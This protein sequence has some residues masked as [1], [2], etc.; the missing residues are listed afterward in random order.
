MKQ[1]NLKLTE[2]LRSISDRSSCDFRVDDD[3]RY[4]GEDKR[5]DI[6]GVQSMTE[7]RRWK[8]SI[9]SSSYSVALMQSRKNQK[10]KINYENNPT[11]PTKIDSHNDKSTPNDNPNNKELKTD[12]S[13]SAHQLIKKSIKKKVIQELSYEQERHELPKPEPA[14]AA[15]IH[16]AQSNRSIVKPILKLAEPT[17]AQSPLSINSNISSSHSSKYKSVRI[18]Q[19]KFD[20][21][22]N[23]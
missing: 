19:K 18:Q 16:G 12:P 15:T 21:K 2:N 1:D 5:I 3:E 17:R 11:N 14:K 7:T 22:A 6:Q 13:I 4:Y 8:M 9:N 20:G 23:N 10:K